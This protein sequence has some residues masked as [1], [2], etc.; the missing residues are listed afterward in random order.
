MLI[1]SAKCINVNVEVVDMMSFSSF[2]VYFT[3]EPD[4]YALVILIVSIFEWFVSGCL[5]I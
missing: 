4:A 2:L 1:L 3:I 5:V